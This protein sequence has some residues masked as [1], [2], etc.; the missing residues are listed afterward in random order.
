[1]ALVLLCGKQHVRVPRTSAQI[2]LRI[3]IHTGKELFSITFQNSLLDGKVDRECPSIYNCSFS[4]TMS[5]EF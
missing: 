3:G 5:K 2:Q 1:M 4:I